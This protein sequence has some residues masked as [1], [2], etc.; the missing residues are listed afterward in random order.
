VLEQKLG[1]VA[2]FRGSPAP[3]LEVFMFLVVNTKN[4]PPN[5][6]KK[7]IASKKP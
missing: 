3:L 7:L 2:A 6:A 4:F 5:K 1:A